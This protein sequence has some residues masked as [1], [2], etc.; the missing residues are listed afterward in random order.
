V[1]TLTLD[2]GTSATKAALWAGAELVAVGRAPIATEH[3]RPGWAEQDPAHWWRSVVGACTEVRTRAPDVYRAVESVGFSAARETFALFDADLAPIR[4]GVLWSDRRAATAIAA[5]GDPG[6]FRARTG[7]VLNAACC[8]A[9]LLWVATEERDRIDAARWVLSPRDW[10]V[11]RITG[12]VVTEPTL[13]SRTGLSALDG[14]RAGPV[15]ETLGDRLPPVVATTT[16]LRTSASADTAAIGLGA[17]IAVVPG[18]GDRACEVL[19]TGATPVVPM[20]SWGTT[21]NVSV[22]CSGPAGSLP[23]HGA[24]SRGALDG[25]V[26]EAGLS[27]S[28]SALGWLGRLTGRSHDELLTL[29]G[30]GSEPGARGVVA[31]LW[32]N[33]ARAPFWRADAHGAFLGLSSAHDV[34]DLGRA[35]VEAVACDVARCVELLAPDAN[36]VALA[37][38]G[39]ADHLWRATVAA[40]TRRDATRRRHDEAASV[41]ARLVVAVALGEP[42]GLDDLNP[43]GETSAPDPAL[44]DA[45]AGVR[46]RSDRAAAAVLDLDLS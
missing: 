5:L 20:V 23:R 14:G 10:I 29:A 25:F 19:G 1:S 36:A 17:G 42:L 28:G 30:A 13:E 40:A 15:V 31:L 43:V 7:V 6:A 8:A 44:V 46:A 45:L 32:L 35:V 16:V 38:G 39:A 2:L 41:G 3:P 11:A 18:A 12:E 24:V 4:A 27:A 21:T 33:G 9:K 22:P 34:A 37:G 26:L